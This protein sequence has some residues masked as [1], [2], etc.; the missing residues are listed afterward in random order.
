MIQIK[1]NAIDS[2]NDYLK[3]NSNL[4]LLPNFTVVTAEEQT[5]GR[6]QRGASWVSEPGKNLLVSILVRD[7]YQSTFM[8]FELIMAVSVSLHEALQQLAVPDLAIKWPNDIM[9]GNKKIG[10][11]LIENIH[12][13]DKRIFSIIGFG[14]N[15]NQIQFDEHPK[16]SSLRLICKQEFDKQLVL[17]QLIL[18]LENKLSNWNEFRVKSILDYQNALFKKG[19]VAQFTS[20]HSRFSGTITGVD[21]EGRLQLTNEF[22]QKMSFD[23][24]EI[25]L[26]F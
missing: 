23:L 17:E 15:V 4:D 13:S 26:D 2:T 7:F 20:Q 1:L 14:L 16:A 5:N 21:L 18:V 24:K 8:P 25:Q 12:K 3:H 6:G 19:I 9:S 22:N 11:I 10:G